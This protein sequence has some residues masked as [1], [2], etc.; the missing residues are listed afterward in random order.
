M[1]VAQ[2]TDKMDPM[3]VISKV[4]PEPHD[5]AHLIFF[6]SFQFWPPGAQKNAFFGSSSAHRQDRPQVYYTKMMGYLDIHETLF[7]FRPLSCQLM[8]AI[9][10]FVIFGSSLAHRQE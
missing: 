2:L 3:Y 6:A 5:D 10:D 7:N 9:L 8:A 4:L 1:A